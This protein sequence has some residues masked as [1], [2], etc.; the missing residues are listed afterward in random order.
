M[1]LHALNQLARLAIVAGLLGSLLIAAPVFA[2]T[3]VVR[4]D[5]QAGSVAQGQNITVSIK[6]DNVS[7]LAGA[8]VHLAF[9]PILL[10]VVDADP[11]RDGVQ[12]T[13]G[14]M[15]VPDQVPINLVDN[16]TG[17][18][19]F[20]VQQINR[21]AITGSGTLMSIN[22]RGKASGTSP[23]TFRAVPSAPTGSNL[24][25]IEGAPIAHTTQSGSVAVTGATATPT[26]TPTPS[27]TAEG[28]TATG[29][30]PTPTPSPTTGTTPMPTSTGNTPTPS[31]T[32]GSGTPGIHIVRPGETL[33]CIGRAYA[34][35]P[36]AIAQ[37]NRIY[38]ASRIFAGQ[39]L[40]IPNVP[41]PSVPA[42]PTCPRQFQGTPP[43]PPPPP[44]PPGCRAT[45]IVVPGDTLLG[46]S[47][48]YG[49]N[50][51]TL[52]QRNNI[53]NLNLIFAGQ[54]LCIP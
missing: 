1:R 42:G 35:I 19:D 49:V 53:F 52:A 29:T 30:T 6:I 26:F 24:A 23:L 16:S 37:Y 36:W 32:A 15:L 13:N 3:T 47:R 27:P 41:W 48:R 14:D 34:V 17:A 2:Q 50:V 39:R 31:A 20:A 45:Y 18:I 28:P 8:E 38:P 12:V 46:I 7:N 40:V 43:P 51:W 9:D 21:N 10:E 33:F 22:F 54:R 5:P 25:E 44:P 11:G 4:V